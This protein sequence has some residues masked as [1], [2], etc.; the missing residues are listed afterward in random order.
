MREASNDHLGGEMFEKMSDGTYVNLKRAEMI[1]FREYEGKTYASVMVYMGARLHTKFFTWFAAD[2]RE[3]AEE[4]V[5]AALEGHRA[6]TKIDIENVVNLPEE[7]QTR[8]KI[9]IVRDENG[10]L[11]EAEIVEISLEE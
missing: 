2:T 7:K 10:F 5:E 11:K 8:K 6:R 1:S 4:R 9:E 3:Q